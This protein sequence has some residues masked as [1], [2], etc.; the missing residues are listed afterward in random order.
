M[1]YGAVL[2]DLDGTLLDTLEDLADSTNAA[3]TDL[4]FPSRPVDEYRVLVGDGI[5]NLALRALPQG[6]KDAQTVDR[7]VRLTRA[8]YGRRWD[9]KTRPY[10][11][12]PELLDELAARQVRMAILS[13]KPDPATREVVAKLLP[14]WT[15]EVVR[16]ARDAV[17]LKPDPAAAL[18]VAAALGAAPRDVLY[19]GDTNTDMQTARAAGM[20]AVGALWGFRTADEL[21]AAGARDLIAHPLDLLPLLG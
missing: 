20:R 2:F 9:A 11:G 19:L 21:L 13:N 16:G 17:P 4:G 8:E 18:D 15:F 12:V 3:L 7:C 5:R 10:P 6:H 14:R 1:R